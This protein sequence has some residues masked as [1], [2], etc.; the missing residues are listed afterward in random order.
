M[1]FMVIIGVVLCVPA[2]S[3]EGHDMPG[4]LPPPPHGGRVAVAEGAYGE[5][6]H[7]HGKDEHGHYEGKAHDSH[8]DDHAIESEKEAHDHDKEHGHGEEKP[9]LYMEVKLENGRELK[10]YPLILDPKRPRMFQSVS[11]GKEVAVSQV[12]IEFP[13]SGQKGLLQAVL[14]GDHWSAQVPAN[15]DYRFFVLV[16]ASHSGEE[17]T[18]KVQVEKRQ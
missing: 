12:R 6:E 9:E 1:K 4:S 16:T 17:K 18:A 5:D 14:K 8:D 15:R 13:R 2:F 11:P 10:I 3:H 7:A